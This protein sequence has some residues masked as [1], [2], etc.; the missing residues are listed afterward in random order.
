MLML[1]CLLI[2][3]SKPV[4]TVDEIVFFRIIGAEF[5]NKKLCSRVGQTQGGPLPP[6]P[7][8]PARMFGQTQEGGG[9]GRH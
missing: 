2:R 5:W 7:P 1:V 8:P 6:P 3:N 4:H 9:G